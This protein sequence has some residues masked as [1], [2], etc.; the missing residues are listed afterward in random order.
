M[1]ISKNYLMSVLQVGP[2]NGNYIVV[3]TATITRV[4]EY[5][6]PINGTPR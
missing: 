3:N 1:R 2:N 4:F 5:R 6:A